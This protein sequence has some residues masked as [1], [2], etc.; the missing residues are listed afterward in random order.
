MQEIFVH[1]HD[2]KENSRGSDKNAIGLEGDH[3]HPL[4][5]DAAERRRP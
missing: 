2:D 4:P 5:R 1:R 3:D